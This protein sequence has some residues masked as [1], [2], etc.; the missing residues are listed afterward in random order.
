MRICVIG[1]PGCG[2]S[3][4]AHEFARPLGLLVLCTDTPE[5]ARA[6]G[7]AIDDRTLYAPSSLGKDWSGLSRW[8]AETWLSLPGPFVIE[9]LALVRALR[10]W[11][12]FWPE[13][14]PPCER[15][16]WCREPRIGLEP[17]A[18]RALVGHDTIANGLLEEWPEL[19][20]LLETHTG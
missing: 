11:R 2:K 16:I 4:L 9:G 5:Q 18:E 13:Q 19:F 6:T 20:D 1:G 7:R 17:G 3:T 8:V 14:R 12:G 15:L 10:K